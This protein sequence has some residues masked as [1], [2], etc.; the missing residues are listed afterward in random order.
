MI[1]YKTNVT[2]EEAIAAAEQVVK[3]FRDKELPNHSVQVVDDPANPGTRV[4]GIIPPQQQ[5]TIFHRQGYIPVGGMLVPTSPRIPETTEQITDLVSSTLAEKYF[6]LQLVDQGAQSL[7]FRANFAAPDGEVRSIKVDKTKFES[8]IAEEYASRG[9]GTLRHIR[10]LATLPESKEHHIVPLV[11]FYDLTKENGVAISIHPHIE[12]RTL[13]KLVSEKG[14]L[15]QLEMKQVFSGVLDAISYYTRRGYLHR[16]LTPGNILIQ[17]DNES[18]ILDFCNSGRT[19]SLDERISTTSFAG[20]RR[21]I[22]PLSVEKLT[23]K[24]T[25]YSQQSEIFEL[26]QNLYFSLTGKILSYVDPEKAVFIDPETGESF[27]DSNGRINTTRFEQYTYKR[28]NEIGISRSFKRL[29][30]K[31]LSLEK[32]FDNFEQ[33]KKEFKR[34]VGLVDYVKRKQKS[35]FSI[36]KTSLLGGLALAT[37]AALPLGFSLFNSNAERTK[38][39]RRITE[40]EKYAVLSQWDDQL[41][42]QNNLV[43]LE[44]LIQ[45]PDF[46][47]IYG[48]DYR[49]KQ[50]L[51]FLTLNKGDKIIFTPR[52]TLKPIPN[53]QHLAFPSFRGKAFIEGFESKE[54]YSHPESLKHDSYEGMASYT[55]YF[56]LEIP[57][58]P[59][60]CYNLIFDIYAHD[61][62]DTP[63]TTTALSAVKYAEPGK[64]IARKRIP[65]VIGNPA[66]RLKVSTLK[67]S[68]YS[69][70]VAVGRVDN[71]L[72]SIDSSVD[73]EVSLF[74]RGDIKSY[75]QRGKHSNVA[76]SPIQLPNVNKRTSSILK[77][78]TSHNN[79]P[80]NYE[81]FPLKSEKVGDLWFWRWD[82]PDDTF[83]EKAI[84]LRKQLYESRQK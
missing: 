35:R 71:E 27:V 20:A 79:N 61:S 54:F 33:F 53:K 60:G 43:D 5:G 77:V 3:E 66:E 69:D 32:R 29:I 50:F 15:S 48:E 6:N 82:L 58:C 11:D 4:I 37:A 56:N 22:D 72:E 59:D 45:T 40:A 64:V 21:V 9:Y 62:K 19:D 24:K 52:L 57:N 30:R 74:Q 26:G 80:I 16:D 2:G 31:S 41:N 38:L 78:V 8:R 23:G 84:E 13:E 83:P 14:K 25:P 46:K 28:V 76:S 36:W 17:P 65:I 1:S 42:I 51:K 67:L 12:G 39:E 34:T 10:T 68:G 47:T 73:C 55:H 63:G 7:V 70:Y 75:S 81:F 18:F 44:V 49:S